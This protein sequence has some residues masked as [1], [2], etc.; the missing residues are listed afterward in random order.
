MLPMTGPA[1]ADELIKRNPDA[2]IVVEELVL[3]DTVVYNPPP[4]LKPEQRERLQRK[5]REVFN[6][7]TL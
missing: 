5:V 4:E 1:V 7:G 6:R 2:Q 3:M